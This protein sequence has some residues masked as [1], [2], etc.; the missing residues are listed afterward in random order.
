[1]VGGA[2]VS[3]RD[4]VSI[5]PYSS[6]STA[7]EEDDKITAHH[8]PRHPAPITRSDKRCSSPD[9]QDAIRVLI[10]QLEHVVPDN[11]Q[12]LLLSTDNYQSSPGSDVSPWQQLDVLLLSLS[13]RCK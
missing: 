12:Q 10:S 6:L 7:D 2:A 9:R 4:L 1:M 3:H 5:I 13:W 11:T 8:D